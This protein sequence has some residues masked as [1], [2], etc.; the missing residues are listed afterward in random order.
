MS[1]ELKISKKRSSKT[2]DELS[3]FDLKDMRLTPQQNASF[4]T[5]LWNEKHTARALSKPS[6]EPHSAG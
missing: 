2:K 6:D 3:Q 4:L 5:A 1:G